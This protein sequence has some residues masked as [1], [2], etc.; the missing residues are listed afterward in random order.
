MTLAINRKAIYA[1]FTDA[2]NESASFAV[3]L[4]ELGIASR[5]EAKPFAM[6][7]ASKKNG[8]EPIKQGLQGPTFVKRDTA[9]ERAMNR[10]LS[11][12]YPKA[13]MPK[14]KKATANKTDTVTKLF[15]QWQAL[16][17]AEK[18]R[19]TTMQLKA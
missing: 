1:V 5:A 18:R 10:V 13:D 3:R 2:D 14:P 4:M 19:F 12:C 8:N 6:E 16:T 17:A 7:W 11:V 9:A 15:T